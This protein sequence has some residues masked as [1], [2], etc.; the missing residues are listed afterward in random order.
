M[1]GWLCGPCGEP[2]GT[3]LAPQKFSDADE[4]TP[5]PLRQGELRTAEGFAPEFH[6]ENLEARKRQP[7]V[8]L[9]SKRSS[10]QGHQSHS[11]PCPAI[12]VVQ[13]L[14]CLLEEKVGIQMGRRKERHSLYR[15]SDE[16]TDI[17]T[18]NIIKGRAD[19][20]RGLGVGGLK[21]SCD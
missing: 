3:H 21:A 4:E 15:D 14:I 2:P 20:S 10:S 5:K 12:P 1:A 19:G 6:N 17:F 8:R 13:A 16:E 11:D 9:M 18:V 7:S